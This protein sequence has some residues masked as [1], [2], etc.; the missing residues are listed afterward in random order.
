[1]TI[2]ELFAIFVS[3]GLLP[4]P[5]EAQQVPPSREEIVVQRM[6]I[7][8]RIVDDDG[9]PILNIQ[10]GDLKAKIDGEAA[11]VEAVDWIASKDEVSRAAHMPD[12]DV[13]DVHGRLL[14]FFFQTDFARARAGGQMKI[15]P[16]AEKM[17]DRLLPTDLVAVVSHDSHLKL[18]QDFTRDRTKVKKA[19]REALLINDPGLEPA[20]S[21]ALSLLSHLELRDAKDA[22][23]A[24]EALGV[25]GQALKPISGP[26]SVFLFGWGLGT[27]TPVGVMMGRDYSY[28]RQ[29][30]DASRTSV[31]SL[32]ITDADSHTLEVGLQQAS[33]DTGGTY[34]K[35]NK[36]AQ[37]AVDQVE[38]TISGRYEVTI[39]TSVNRGLHE[40]QL[41]LS[42]K[43][44]T[45]LHRQSY[46]TH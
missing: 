12:V 25:I 39:K 13:D 36:F 5:A 24:E 27:Y 45:V 29:M 28:A 19:I 40:V 46:E 23:S 21:D 8:A 20:D 31:F 42:G 4:L 34:A 37:I 17:V 22:S 9:A 15:I 1:M 14:V 38:K 2:R 35:T 41:Q 44:G 43:H 10:P 32:D 16:Y 33:A 18:R 26:K 6:I 30:L 11:E 7:D 3:F